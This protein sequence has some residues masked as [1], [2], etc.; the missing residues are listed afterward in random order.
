MDEDYY[1]SNDGMMTYIWG[2]PLWHF[3]HTMSFNYPVN[4]SD[5]DKENYKNYI[6]SMGKILPCKYC[7]D[8][9][10][11][12]I[13]N[14]PLYK[15]GALKNRENFSKW[16]F[17]FHNEVN[18]QLGKPIHKNYNEVRDMYETFRARCGNNNNSKKELGCTNPINKIKKKCVLYIL[19]KNKKCKSFNCY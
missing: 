4:P 9:F 16:M 10:K 8:N 1:K 19:P 14:V 3:L 2:P 18:K 15:N 7:R 6:M 12:N 13:K 11:D 17:D 5:T